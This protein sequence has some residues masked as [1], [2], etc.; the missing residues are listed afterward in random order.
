MDGFQFIIESPQESQSH[1]KRPRLVTSCDNW[2]VHRA[3][4]TVHIHGLRSFSFSRLKK[5]KCLQPSS[6]S[7]C[8]ACKVAKIQCRF[9]DRERYFAERSRAIAGPNLTRPVGRPE[10]ASHDATPSR[11]E[12]TVAEFPVPNALPASSLSM[13]RSLSYSP[14]QSTAHNNDAHVR[15]QSYPLDHAKSSGSHNGHRP[16]Q[17]ASDFSYGRQVGQS[18]QYKASLLFDAGHPSSPQRAWMQ[19]FIPLFISNMGA[20][21]PFISYEDIYDKFRRQTLSPLLSNCIA[22]LAAR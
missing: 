7:H 4:T 13:R 17:S 21:C 14:P 22:G 2:Y 20:Q 19:Q 8:E 6:D 10:Y 16:T 12:S 3:C 11:P 1:K 5:I 15:Y 18:P 9:R